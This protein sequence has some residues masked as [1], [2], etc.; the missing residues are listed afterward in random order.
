MQN[1]LRAS[2]FQSLASTQKRVL[3]LS[4]S[5]CWSRTFYPFA[6]AATWLLA[7]I[8][9]LTFQNSSVRNPFAEWFCPRQNHCHDHINGG[10]GDNI[11]H[12]FKHC[13]HKHLPCWVPKGAWAS[14]SS[15]LAFPR[16]AAEPLT[17]E[18]PFEHDGQRGQPPQPLDVLPVDSGIDGLGH[19][20]SQPAVLP[21]VLPRGK[22][23]VTA[24]EVF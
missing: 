1:H 21:E 18:D 8:F 11:S 7:F 16:V 3:S 9:S 2:A 15:S 22:C 4:N 20:H 5:K 10:A 24:G 19:V 14:D 13:F 17:P 6:S 12:L 23:Q